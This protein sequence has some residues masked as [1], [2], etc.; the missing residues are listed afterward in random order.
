MSNAIKMKMS[1]I[2]GVLHMSFGVFIKGMNLVYKGKYL[3]MLTEV[4]PGF[5]ILWGLF[6][7][8]DAQIIIKWF[9][10]N[11]IDDTSKTVGPITPA[12]GGAP[13]Y[14]Y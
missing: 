11:N 4:V 13:Y 6:G 8:M 7:W 10:N 1:V 2:F 12:G 3:D 5:I 14:T 9:Y